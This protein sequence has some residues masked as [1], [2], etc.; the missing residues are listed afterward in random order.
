MLPILTTVVVAVIPWFILT[1]PVFSAPTA[2]ALP[3]KIESQDHALDNPLSTFE[4][5]SKRDASFVEVLVERDIDSEY[6]E[7]NVFT[8]PRKRQWGGGWGGGG[9]RNC[10]GW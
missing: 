3:E 4:A 9:H 8:A 1:K 5:P 2:L 7:S 10:C 6:T